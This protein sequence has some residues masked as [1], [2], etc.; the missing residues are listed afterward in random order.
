MTNSPW[1]P[2]KIHMH[3]GGREVLYVQHEVSRAIRKTHTDVLRRMEPARRNALPRYRENPKYLTRG[4]PDDGEVV[5]WPQVAD[6][7]YCGDL[8][9]GECVEEARIKGVD[10]MR[11]LH[12]DGT[13]AL[14]PLDELEVVHH[15]IAG[16]AASDD[17]KLVDQCLLG[18]RTVEEINFAASERMH[19]TVQAVLGMRSDLELGCDLIVELHAR[20]FGRIF[21]WGGRYRWNGDIVVGK[22][23]FETPAPHVIPTLML[24]FE[25]E[26]R[27]IRSRLGGELTPEHPSYWRQLAQVYFKLCEIH[28]FRDGNGRVSRLLL[29]LL[30][31]QTMEAPVPLDWS[32][33]SRSQRRTDKAFEA[34]RLDGDLWPLAQLIYRV[35]RTTADQLQK[36]P[37]NCRF[38][39]RGVL[40]RVRD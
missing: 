3:P 38:D 2:C 40:R 22:L 12:R 14:F 35:F 32:K 29:M 5:R 19:H 1:K 25:S 10:V 23:E 16:M 24:Q 15:N 36:K 20:I 11:V 34:A 31:F 30:M 7:V 27:A 37:P 13:E 6:I 9:F 26:L 39:G 18:V 4:A 28:P 17:Q 33:L 21:P 8:V